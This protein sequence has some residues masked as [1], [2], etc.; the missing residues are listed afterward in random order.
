MCTVCCL[1]TKITENITVEDRRGRAK[2]K[3]ILAKNKHARIELG[4][5]REGKMHQ[6]KVKRSEEDMRVKGKEVKKVLSIDS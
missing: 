3:A 2:R 6:K 5:E 1:L 4:N